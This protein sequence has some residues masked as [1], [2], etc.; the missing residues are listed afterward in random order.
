MTVYTARLSIWACLL[1]ARV[2]SAAERFLYSRRCFY[3]RLLLIS[4]RDGVHYRIYLF[5]SHRSLHYGY[6]NE[7]TGRNRKTRV[8]LSSWFLNPTKMENSRIS[9]IQDHTRN[10]LKACSIHTSGINSV[11]CSPFTPRRSMIIS[12]TANS[13]FSCRKMEKLNTFVCL[14][15]EPQLYTA[16]R[17][18]CTTE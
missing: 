14:Y 4:L 3:E 1:I 16:D 12:F 17:A 10:A 6:V 8:Q 11:F 2:L 18:T 7:S 15:S 13:N 9:Q 5:Y